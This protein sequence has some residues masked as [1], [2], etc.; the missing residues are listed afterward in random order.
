VA[1]RSMVETFLTKVN[2]TSFRQTSNKHS[3]LEAF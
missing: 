2:L 1:S 3:G